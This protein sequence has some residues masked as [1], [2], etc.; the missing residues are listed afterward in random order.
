MRTSLCLLICFASCLNTSAQSNAPASFQG[1]TVGAVVRVR[2]E[3]PLVLL[4]RATL[5]EI[6]ATNIVLLGKDERF[7]LAKSVTDLSDP[8]GPTPP[9]RPITTAKLTAAESAAKRAAPNPDYRSTLAS[10]R[11]ATLGA[12]ANEPGHA[13]ASEY[14][15]TTMAEVLNGKISQADLVAQAEKVL[16][17]VDKYLPERAKDPRFEDQIRLLQDFVKR[18]KAGEQIMVPRVE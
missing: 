6:N 10:V 18:S 15:D 13:K 7:V 5:K 8:I 14:Y 2:C 17:D 3:K 16:A 4:S 11:E 9:A 1:Y 12:F